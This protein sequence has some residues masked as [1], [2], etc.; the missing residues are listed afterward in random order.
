MCWGGA[1]DFI[2]RSTI[3][4]V[5]EDGAWRGSSPTANTLDVFG[6]CLRELGLRQVRERWGWAVEKLVELKTVFEMAGGKGQVDGFGRVR[7]RASKP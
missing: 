4:E 7:G 6:K 1:A 5:N 2:Q 3:C